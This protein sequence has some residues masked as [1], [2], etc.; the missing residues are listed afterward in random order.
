MVFVI[1]Q[2]HKCVCVW[3]ADNIDC[4][5][6]LQVAVAG[7]L[8]LWTVGRSKIETI[9]EED[10]SFFPIAGCHVSLSWGET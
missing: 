4:T 8:E 5:D 10:F 1:R 6:V 9:V 7:C 2:L 3:R